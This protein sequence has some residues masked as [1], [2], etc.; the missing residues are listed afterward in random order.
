MWI[1]FNIQTKMDD[2]SGCNAQDTG[3]AYMKTMMFRPAVV[4]LAMLA[5]MGAANSAR[6]TEEDDLRKQ[7]KELNGLTGDDSSRTAA[8]ELLKDKAKLA[9]LLRLADDMAKLDSKQFKYN[10]AMA[11][12]MAAHQVKNYDVAQRFYKLCEKQAKEMKSATKIVDAFEGQVMILSASKRFDDAEELCLKI[13][14]SD[15]DELE[16]LKPFITEQLIQIRT[17]QGKVDQALKLTD[18]LIKLDE[19]GWYFVRLKGWVLLEAGRPEE[20]AKAYLDAIDRLEKSDGLKPDE[21]DK[22][23]DRIRYTLSNVYV[24]MNQVDKSIEQL[25][26]LLK[27]K[28]DNASYNN[29]LGYVWADHDMNLDEAEKLIRK[30]LDEDRK[31]R[32]Q[33]K[34]LLPDEDRDNAA[35]LDSLGWVLYKK[36]QYAEAKKA[37][38][39][40]VKLE[41]GQHMEI[42]DHLADI[43]MA[44]GEKADAV[45]VWKKAI[46]LDATSKRD[47]KR[48]AEIIKK[49]KAADGK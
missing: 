8:R 45:A 4:L 16:R 41:D 25:K 19:G 49:L 32:K 18:E 1:D 30:A 10:S 47:I 28:P 23:V 33:N 14:E 24:E 38:L 27:K 21:Q 17:R 13:L 15:L 7:I 6:A 9:K 11:L 31:V 22:W 37:M 12:A 36:K 5:A 46:D 34:D 3:D 42:L 20:S 44:L 48:R 29:D 35:Y 40:A 26:I 43:H 2:C 39:E